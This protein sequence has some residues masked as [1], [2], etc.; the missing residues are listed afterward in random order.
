[1]LRDVAILDSLN[2]K[3]LAAK[4]IED[5]WLYEIFPCGIAMTLCNN[6]FISVASSIS[7][8]LGAVYD[9]A[10]VEEKDEYLFVHA[11]GSYFLKLL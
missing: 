4:G 2:K 1:M 6:A 5:A 7:D 8:V 3:T 9:K 10:I 11:Y